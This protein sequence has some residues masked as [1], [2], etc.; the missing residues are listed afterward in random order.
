MNFIKEERDINIKELLLHVFAKWRSILATGTC[1]V[2][3]VFII[4]F[5]NVLK[6]RKILGNTVVIVELLKYI[7]IGFAVPIVIS[8][9]FYAFRYMFSDI[10]KSTNEYNMTSEL[11]LLGGI[12]K[13]DIKNNCFIDKIIKKC[14]GIKILHADRDKL[15]KRVY[16][17]IAAES[18]L[19][20]KDVYMIAVVSSYKNETTESFVETLNPA[21]AM[22]N[23]RIVSAGDI[24]VNENAINIVMEADYVVVVEQQGKSKYSEFEQTCK[25]LESWNKKILGTVL[26]DVDAL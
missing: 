5:A 21:L 6:Y 25:N 20:D 14:M 18:L 11:K 9:V 17:V 12:P 8:I 15:I 2:L 26:L 24:L 1:G 22:Q 4:N 13:L 19:R 23:L 16:N 10:I 7:A 3:L